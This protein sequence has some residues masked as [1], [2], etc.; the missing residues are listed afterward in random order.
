GLADLGHT[1]DPVTI[2]TALRLACEADITHAIVSN[3]QSLSA[4]RTRRLA[5]KLQRDALIARDRGCAAP[6]CDAPPAWTQAHHITHW[7]NGGTTDP[8][9][10][11]L[12]CGRHHR[13]VHTG[14]W[15]ITTVN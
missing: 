6:G 15:T 9:N 13:A 11:V 12:L 10:L 3:G 2:H 4:G 7:A 1:R 8:D 14:Q 5:T